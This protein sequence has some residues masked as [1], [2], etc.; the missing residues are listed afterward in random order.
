V[1]LVDEIEYVLSSLDEL[2]V[3]KRNVARIF[4]KTVAEAAQAPYEPLADELD[5]RRLV[6][7]GLG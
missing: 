6:A 3:C 2:L 4:A 5:L 7:D 1:H